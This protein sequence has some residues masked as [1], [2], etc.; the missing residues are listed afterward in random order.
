MDSIGFWFGY[1]PQEKEDVQE[2][3]YSFFS[4]LCLARLI[5]NLKRNFC[6]VV[7]MITKSFQI[8]LI[9]LDVVFKKS[10]LKM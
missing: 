7:Q 5:L 9:G 10:L 1:F 4:P 8:Y 6:V 2:R 3:V